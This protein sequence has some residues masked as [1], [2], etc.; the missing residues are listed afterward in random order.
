MVTNPEFL[1]RMTFT[2]TFSPAAERKTPLMKFS[3]IQ[4]SSSPILV[5]LASF[6]SDQQL[7]QNYLPKSGLGRILRGGAAGRWD[8]AHITG[9]RS[10]IGKRHLAGGR[11]AVGW[12]AAE[13]SVVFHV[14]LQRTKALVFVDQQFDRHEGR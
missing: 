6:L 11:S 7:T 9:R 4:G 2:L 13:G 12:A 8:R 3:S 5:S 14:D 10:T 1:S